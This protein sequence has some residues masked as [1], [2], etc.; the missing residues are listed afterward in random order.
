MANNKPQITEIKYGMKIKRS[1][2]QE[3]EYQRCKDLDIGAL[4]FMKNYTYVK[5]GERVVQFSMRPYTSEMIW[6]MNAFKRVVNMASRQAGKC[7]CGETV[8]KVRNK[9][10]GEETNMTIS[11]IYEIY[12]NIENSLKKSDEFQENKD[13]R[14]SKENS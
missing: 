9:K 3:L 12:N 7:V 11:N 10:T 2:A 6:M 13:D 14:E 8:I 5:D 1:P 4:Y